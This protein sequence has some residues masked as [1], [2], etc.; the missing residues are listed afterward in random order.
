MLPEFIKTLKCLKSVSSK[1]SDLDVDQDSLNK[2]WVGCAGCGFLFGHFVWRRI[3]DHKTGSCAASLM[4]QSRPSP[5]LWLVHRADT[6]L[7][8][9]NR[10]HVTRIL[11]SDWLA[12]AGLRVD[13]LP[14]THRGVNISSLRSLNTQIFVT[15]LSMISLISSRIW[16]G[17]SW[18]IKYASRISYFIHSRPSV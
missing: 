11:G 12:G 3:R 17:Q 9:V 1:S 13:A 18:R 5:C 15:M 7:W 2:G 6:G 14:R 10:S 4:R 16:Q 8:L